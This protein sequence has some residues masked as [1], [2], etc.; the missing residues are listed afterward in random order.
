MTKKQKTDLETILY[1]VPKALK[2]IEITEND[3]QMFFEYS[4]KGLHKEKVKQSHFN[5]GFNA[6]VYGKIYR[7]RQMEM[8]EDGIMSGDMPYYIILGANDK[9]IVKKWWQFWKDRY[10]FVHNPIPRS[11][12]DFMKKEMF[13]GNDTEI[14]EECYQSLLDKNK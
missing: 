9:I 10:T 12:V 1:F 13:K 6:L 11:V 4:D 14:I 5:D 7:G 3:I 8:W 2:N